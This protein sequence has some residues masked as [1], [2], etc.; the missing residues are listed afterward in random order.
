MSV[1]LTAVVEGLPDQEAAKK[2]CCHLDLHIS[3]VF[4]RKGKGYID[5][6]ISGFNQASKQMPWLV[7]RDLDH[8]ADCPPDLKSKL[9]P[10]PEKQMCFCIAVREVESWLIADSIKFAEFLGIPSKLIP[11]DPE[12][13]DYPKQMVIQLAGKSKNSDIR[14]DIIPRPESL[15]KEGPAYASRLAEFASER[16]RPD[17]AAKKC[18][19]LRYCIRKLSGL[20]NI[21]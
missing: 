7:L 5:S 21:K 13:L 8:D 19:S 1:Y 11:A 18:E 10:S 20:K 14:E 2:I 17:V 4:G 6:R 16:W 15:R 3:E 12:T 9:L